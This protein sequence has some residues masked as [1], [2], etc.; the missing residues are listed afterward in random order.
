MKQ[1]IQKLTETFSPS[2]YETAICEV[3]RKEIKAL[4]RRNPRGRPGQ[5]DRP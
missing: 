3:I 2:G 4:R 5:P 1:L